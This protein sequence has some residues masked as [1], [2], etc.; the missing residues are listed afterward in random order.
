[1]TPRRIFE[2]PEKALLNKTNRPKKNIILKFGR[3]LW[4]KCQ[5][6]AFLDPQNGGNNPVVVQFL[7]R[8]RGLKV[9]N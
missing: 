5:F 3:K 1:M 4:K 9:L 2:T 8:I 7:D 6:L